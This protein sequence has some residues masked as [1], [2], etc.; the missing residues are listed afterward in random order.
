MKRSHACALSVL[1]GLAA[2]TLVLASRVPVVLI[3]ASVESTAD[4][5]SLPG[6]DSGIITVRGCATCSTQ[7]FYFA[8]EHLLIVQGRQ[9]DLAQMSAA[10]RNAGKTP[11]TVHYRRSDSQVT[12][13]VLL[14]SMKSESAQ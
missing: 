4:E 2:P 1:L 7:T 9:V 10:L 11:V 6:V 12:R 3:E 5:I 8:K 14:T 13:I